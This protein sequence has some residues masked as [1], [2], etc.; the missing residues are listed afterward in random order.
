MYKIVYIIYIHNYIYNVLVF[1]YYFRYKKK[2]ILVSL[3]NLLLFNL[4]YLIEK[5]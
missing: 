4:Y 1:N 2:R 3:K 5:K